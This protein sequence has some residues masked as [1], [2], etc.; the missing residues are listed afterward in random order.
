MKTK[1]KMKLADDVAP[2]TQ[3]LLLYVTTM[4]DTARRGD[5]TPV[6]GRHEHHSSR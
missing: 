4:V 5:T 6:R 1:M 3:Q 2:L